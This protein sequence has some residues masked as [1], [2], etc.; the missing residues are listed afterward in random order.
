MSRATKKEEKSSVRLE[1]K[2]SI[3]V[4]DHDKTSHIKAQPRV[5]SP[6]AKIFDSVPMCEYF[7]LRYPR[8]QNHTTVRKLAGQRAEESLREENSGCEEKVSFN[9]RAAAN[10]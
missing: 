1:R 6:K 10:L 7:P 2:Q 5:C 9:R 3:I 4:F 8:A